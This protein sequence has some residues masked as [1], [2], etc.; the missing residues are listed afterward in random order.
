MQSALKMQTNETKKRQCDAV[1]AK[2]RNQSNPNAMKMQQLKL[3]NATCAARC[4][5]FNASILIRSIC[6]PFPHTLAF[7]TTESLLNRDF[8]LV[9]DLRRSAPSLAFLV[10]ERLNTGN[11]SSS[12]SS[13][14]NRSGLGSLHEWRWP[15]IVRE[16]LRRLIFCAL[17]ATSSC[18][19]PRDG[20]VTVILGGVRWR[21]GDGLS[22]R[23]ASSRPMNDSSSSSSSS[24]S[25]IVGS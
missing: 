9:D 12:D 10:L 8:D 6:P 11:S 16:Y 17:R 15:D 24:S 1:Y 14:V 21:T 7:S 25:K 18:A 4:K 23:R 20:S 19:R 5:C 13:T 2:R 3:K 22:L